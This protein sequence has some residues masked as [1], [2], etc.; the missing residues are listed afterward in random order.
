MFPLTR[1]PFGVLILGCM[2]FNFHRKQVVGTKNPC[3]QTLVAIPGLALARKR[4]RNNLPD[5]D[6]GSMIP[7]R[8]QK[9]KQEAVRVGGP[10][11]T[12]YKPK[13]LRPFILNPEDG[14][15][16][17]HGLQ[18][19]KQVV[20]T[21]NPCQET[22]VAIPGLALARKRGRNNLPDRDPGSMI[23]S[24]KQ[25][26]TTPT[27]KQTPQPPKGGQPWSLSRPPYFRIRGGSSDLREGQLLAKES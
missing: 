13:M 11:S 10:N 25:E 1:V 22:L 3:Q 4:G 20:G 8:K 23:P 6:P 18:F 24:R 21:K 7:S 26:A 15:S 19:S 16:R 5:R 2:A 27:P 9:R 17:M 12:S 14:L